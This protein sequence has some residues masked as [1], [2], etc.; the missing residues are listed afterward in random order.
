MNVHMFGYFAIALFFM[1]GNVSL[2][3][4]KIMLIFTGL[5]ITLVLYELTKT[6]FNTNIARIAALI[7]ALSPE[8]LT[9]V[10][11]VGGPEIPSALFTL[12]T[13]YLLYHAPASKRKTVLALVAGL[14]LFI[15]WYAWYFNFYVFLTFLPLL[16]IY[17]A[18]TYKEFKLT[19]TL[20]FLFLL[21]SFI[22]EYRVLLNLTKVMVGIMVPSLI[23]VAFFAIHLLKLKKNQKKNTLTTFTMLFL[24]LYTLLYSL[25]LFENFIPQVQRFIVSA[26][27][28]IKLVTS[29]IV[30]DVGILSRAFSL[31]EVNKY[32]DMYWSG[33]YDYLGIVVVFLAFVSLAKIDRLKEALLVLSFPMLQA[34]LWGLFVTI[35]GFQP[36]FIVCSS[37]FYFVLAALS[38]EMILS[39]A[40]ATLNMANKLHISL[41]IKTGKMI[42]NINVKRLV[43]VFAA[44]LL[45]GS[46]FNFTYPIYDKQ[47]RVME[48]WNYPYNLDWLNAFEWIQSNTSSGDII[49]ARYS[50]FPWYTDRMTVILSPSI[51][52]N[53]NITGLVKIIRDFKISYLVVD[54]SLAWQQ[55]AL[56]LLYISPTPFLGSEVVWSSVGPH[57]YKVVIYDVRNIAYGDYFR[58]AKPISNCDS[59][60]YWSIFSLY[61]NGTIETDGLDKVEGIAS[62]KVTFNVKENP[63]PSAAVTFNPPDSWD[64]GNATMLK[65]WIKAPFNY[66]DIAIKLATDPNNYVVFQVLGANSQN[67]IEITIPLTNVLSTY[68][69]PNLHSIDFIQIYIRGVA[70]NKTYTF[71]LDNISVL[72]ERFVISGAGKL[73]P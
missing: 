49:A 53:L 47:K 54:Q 4:A 73:R 2:F 69:I 31:E 34:V 40:L 29:N 38:I 64:L 26:Q 72:S 32:W 23:V 6:L 42:H 48:G 7:T 58:Y 22:I 62:V 52:P 68:G 44:I 24:A 63:V 11:L 8:L 27:P 67:W 36:R 46:F 17:I 37:L 57:G 65:F 71:W 1:L 39:Q 35:D 19:D 59:K 9:H 18:S 70:T 51:Y 60:Q 16:F 25:V 61:G 12:F 50:Y 43:A 33:V 55:K 3:S 66:T 21:S 10:G 28:G 14:S 30:R 45:L 13:I 5:L 56:A 20:F 41:K 15:A